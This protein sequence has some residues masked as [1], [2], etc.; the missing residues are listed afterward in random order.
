MDPAALL[1]AGSRGQ[2]ACQHLLLIMQCRVTMK[3]SKNRAR[4]MHMASCAVQ[5]PSPP[6]HGELHLLLLMLQQQLGS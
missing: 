4:K 6:V 2:D 1:Q 5:H 3:M